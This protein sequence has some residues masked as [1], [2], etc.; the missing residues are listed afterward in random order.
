MMKIYKN[1]KIL[2]LGLGFAGGGVGVA[3]FFARQGADVVIIDKKTKQELKESVEKLK[4]YRNIRFSLGIKI[5]KHRV[6]SNFDMAVLN[7]AVDLR[8]TIVKKIKKANVPIASEIG[9][10]LK[11]CRG[12]VIAITGT[13]GKGTTATLVYTI[14]KKAFRLR[15][16][17]AKKDVVLGGN[18]GVSLLEKLP[19]I[20]KNTFVVLEVSSFQLDLLALAKVK[21]LFFVSALTNIY[22]D[23]LDRYN[24]FADYKKSKLT[25]FKY[26]ARHRIDGRKLA[27]KLPRWIDANKIKLIGDHNKKNIA[28]AI[29]IAK[30][31]NIKKEIIRKVVYSFR[32]LPHRLE[33]VGVKK[34]IKFYNDSYSTTP[35]STIAALKSLHTFQSSPE[36]SRGA[37]LKSFNQ[38]V[39]LIA[40]GVSKGA[41]FKNLAREAEKRAKAVIL[42]GKSAQEIWRAFNNVKSRTFDIFDV[43]MAGTLQK[44]VRKAKKIAQKGDIILFSPAC[45][46]FDQFRNARERGETFTKLVKRK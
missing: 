3:Q 5:T 44:A 13:K 27:A 12:K 34:R 19:S 40:G 9:I 6:F 23:H 17:Q 36:R 15:S 10:F 38:K 37:A 8:S 22:P 30:R 2:I 14:L 45:A 26:Y 20:S 18:I 33:Y 31:L 25:V 28:L 39:I 24:S 43:T 7:P 29:E 4:K 21:P 11:H 35:D 46:S 42:F 1:R 16:R 41:S 32:G